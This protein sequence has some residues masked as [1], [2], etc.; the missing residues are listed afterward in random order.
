MGRNKREEERIKEVARDGDNALHMCA[1]L[2]I[3]GGR[4][5]RECNDCYLSWPI[6]LHRHNRHPQ[7]SRRLSGVRQTT[8]RSASTMTASLTSMAN[9]TQA[10]AALVPRKFRT[11]EHKQ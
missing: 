5:T 8:S 4:G 6:R 2:L 10:T 9:P 1:H 11:L 7:I 3:R